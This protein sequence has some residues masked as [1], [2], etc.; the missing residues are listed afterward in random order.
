MD[1]GK[2]SKAGLL[3]PDATYVFQLGGA[4]FLALVIGAAG[5]AALCYGVVSGAFGDVGAGVMVA[6]WVGV[7][8]FG[9]GGL[10]ALFVLSRFKPAMTVSPEGVVAP[11]IGMHLVPWHD[12]R[13]VREAQFANSSY[14]AID[15]R[16]EESYLARGNARLRRGA[17]ASRRLNM[18]LLCIAPQLFGTNTA[19]LLSAIE[20]RWRRHGGADDSLSKEIK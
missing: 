19:E 2:G 12:I 4:K 1:R 14:V 10:I 5:F 15:L 18:P 7:A 8:F 11:T 3:D 9:L 16:D 13:A 17:T 20:I 6:S